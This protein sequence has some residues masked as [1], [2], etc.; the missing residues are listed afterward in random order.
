MKTDV[1]FWY[2]PKFEKGLNLNQM[3]DKIVTAVQSDQ[4]AS[5]KNQNKSFYRSFT[6]HFQSYKLISV[7]KVDISSF[8]LN[9]V[10]LIFI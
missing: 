9:Y 2:T 1:R 7:L 6:G 8:K 5:E 4:S 10:D 3:V